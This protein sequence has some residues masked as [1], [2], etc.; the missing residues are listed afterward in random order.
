MWDTPTSHGT[1]L[2]VPHPL[3]FIGSHAHLIISRTLAATP[4]SSFAAARDGCAGDDAGSRAGGRGV[5]D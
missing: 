4:T 5:Y 2:D 1:R 3:V